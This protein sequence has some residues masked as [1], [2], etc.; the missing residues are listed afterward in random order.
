LIAVIGDEFKTVF[1]RPV[2]RNSKDTSL[3]ADFVLQPA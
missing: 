2:M 3:T 1:L